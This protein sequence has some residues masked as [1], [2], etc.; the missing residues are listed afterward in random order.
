MGTTEDPQRSWEHLFEVLPEGVA[1]VDEFSVIGRANERL[2]TQEVSDR[3]EMTTGSGEF[4]MHYQPIVDL[5]TTEVVGFEALMRWQHPERGWVS[6]GVFIPLAEQSDLILKLNSFALNEAVSAAG[7]WERSDVPNGHP[8]VTVNLSARQFHDPNLVPMIEG[9]LIAGDLPTEQLV[10]EI[11]ESVSRLDVDET[12]RVIERLDR[13]GIGIALGDVGNGY[14]TL[15]YLSLLHPRI[16]KIDQSSL[17]DVREAQ[18]DRLLE[19]IVALGH[20]LNMT[21]LAQRLETKGQ[22]AKLR[23]LGC[24]LGQGFLYS[25]AV[26]GAEASSLVGRVMGD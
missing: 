23:H 13:L 5:A 11:T 17:V 20:Q 8:Y 16:V 18:D 22:S 19:S 26:P 12:V 4:S 21:V 9:A 2:A 15:S 10:I 6:P 1:V 14:S 7:S 24:D 3:D 25:P